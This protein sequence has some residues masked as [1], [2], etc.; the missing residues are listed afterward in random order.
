MSARI[1]VVDDIEANRR[2]LQAKLEARYFDVSAAP[3][4]PTAIELARTNEPDIILLDV[5]MPGMNGY[6]V[7]ARLKADPATALIPVVMVTALS[8]PEHRVKGLQAGAEDFITKPFNDF[9]LMTRIDGLMRYNDVAAELRQREG[10]GGKA[11][12]FDEADREVLDRDIKVVVVDDNPRQSARLVKA[13]EAA[14]HRAGTYLEPNGIRGGQGGVD[15]M[16]LSLLSDSFDPLKV[17]AQFRM[18]GRT[19]AISILAIADPYDPET[20]T[21][22]MGLGAS[23]LIFTPID[24]Q[25]LL[26]RIQTQARR[27]RYID[28]LRRRVDLGM[29]LAV[30]D[31]LTGLHNRRFMTAQI[32]KWIKRSEIDG[33]PISVVALDIDHFKQVNDRFGHAA[34]DE[35][36]REF[37]HRLGANVRPGDIVCRQGGEEFVVVMPEAKAETALMVAERVR[38]AVAAEPFVVDDK[39]MKITVSAGVSTTIG[40]GETSSDLLSRADLALYQAKSQG[41]NRVESLAA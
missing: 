28:I 24:E 10:G 7:C 14:G 15:V 23:D 12:V 16:L 19:R 18:S 17:C 20:A 33:A 34:G 8:E 2:L 11:G 26:A 6:E 1:L 27:K 3:D 13:L 21:R 22:A 30:T 9:A 40:E 32:E 25:E 38:R 29:E 5:M 41:R 39:S 36:L 37:A 35:V 31:P 4:G